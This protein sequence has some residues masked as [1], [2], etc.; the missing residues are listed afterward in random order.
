MFDKTNS[1]K[2]LSEAIYFFLN[3]DALKKDPIESKL[4]TEKNKD[5]YKGTISTHLENIFNGLS[6]EEIENKLSSLF[7]ND[8]VDFSHVKPCSATYL[9][10]KI[11]VFI[12]YKEI[13]KDAHNRG[14]VV[15]HPIEHYFH[16][17][18]IHLEDM[19]KSFTKEEIELLI[20]FLVK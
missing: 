8:V 14:L 9:A 19:F 2:A 10:N 13:N 17:I 16:Y 5:A 1:V 12:N 6:N 18:F 3:Y 7:K 20:S 15:L 4:L 11:Y